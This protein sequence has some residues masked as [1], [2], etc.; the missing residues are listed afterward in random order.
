MLY[1]GIELFFYFRCAGIIGERL[2]FTVH[3]IC[4]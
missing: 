4:A 1:L 2:R 3:N